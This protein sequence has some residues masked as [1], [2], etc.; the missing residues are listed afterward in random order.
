M[1][2][3]ITLHVMACLCMGNLFFANAQQNPAQWAKEN[4]AKYS[5]QASAVSD[6]VK[7]KDIENFR[8]MFHKK[9]Y[10][11]HQY[12]KAQVTWNEALKQLSD[13]GRF[14]DLIDAE[15]KCNFD[16]GQKSSVSREYI[17]DFM[18]EVWY[19]LGIM[20][21][22]V[23]NGNA[24]Q[25]DIYTERYIKSV[26]YYGNIEIN[27][28]NY[29]SRFHESCFA[30]PTSA[31]NIYYAFLDRMDYI[32]SGKECSA[33]EKAMCEML[34]TVALQAW[35]QPLRRDKTDDNV[36]SVDRFRHHV[37]WVG[38]NGLAYRSL[39]PVACMIKSIP[40]IDVLAEV[41][42]NGISST[43]QTTN[44]TSFWTEGFTADGA[45]WGHGMQCLIW[46]YPIDGT[47]AALNLLS[48]VKGTSWER[49]L[50]TENKETLFNYLRG[51]NW[52]YY[53]GYNLPCL[54][55]GSFV[56][57]K[58]RESI[59]SM[60][61]VNTLLKD[62]VS[63]FTDKE[64]AELEQFKVEAKKMNLMMEGYADGCY[65]GTRWFFNNDD[66]IKK[67]EDYHI[68]VNMASVR[69]DGIESA[70]SMADAY[71]FT[72][73]DG[74]TLFQRDGREYMSILGAFDV[75]HAPGITAR[76][77]M[78][79]LNPITN[80]RG[81]CSKY[82][83]AAGATFG[84]ENAV[85][86]FKFEKMNASNKK[87]VNDTVGRQD[88]NS[89]LYGVQA[90]KSYFIFGDYMLALGA[91]ITNLN[92]SMK[93]E[94]HTTVE[95]TSQ[96]GN[97]YLLNKG[98]KRSIQQGEFAINASSD[99]Q[100]IVQEGKFAYTVLPQ[101]KGKA[102]CSLTKR[103]ADWVKMNPV[104]KNGNTPA[105]CDVLQIWINH[106]QKPVNDQYGYVVYSGKGLPAGE[107][108]FE[109]LR[110]DTRIQ[111]AVSADQK[112]LGAVF[113]KGGEN[114]KSGNGLS[115]SV[116]APC[117]VLLEKNG[118]TWNVAI[119]DAEHN[120]AL[121]SIKLTLN[122]KEYVIE[123]SGGKLTGKCVNTIIQ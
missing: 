95:Q 34:K 47:S 75:L 8:Q 20:A 64:L 111:A 62:W 3:T 15:K 44:E 89:I 46:G 68:I 122:G 23:V 25:N 107:V 83:F 66:L 16:N 40:M 12:R 49:K 70:P 77:G 2:R 5:E 57:E 80:W 31:M 73:C 113:Y 81:Y 86:G 61:L 39:L 35:T 103:E 91:G 108:P 93:E 48:M 112:T 97:I 36:V 27:R 9:G 60:L 92:T 45:G 63:S 69:C 121:K 42:Q 94:I 37:W 33:E 102:F 53:K 85:A 106:G 22:A 88:K 105:E 76:V 117:A 84:K 18:S 116:S 58:G 50:N 32:E 110:N 10:R 104:N 100:W 101:Y 74:M 21:D 41:A 87:G 7:E 123:M 6:L 114:L 54:G 98:T 11:K 78:D 19:R 119:T 59:K 28:S 1:K 99:M 55:R 118:E 72:T 120:T 4:Y 29:V 24:D 90:Y 14:S 13:N 109:V 43:S 52:Y 30:I 17:S 115:L 51:S 65:N 71:N 82:N 56:Y 67:N 38:G 26:L 96:T 79:K